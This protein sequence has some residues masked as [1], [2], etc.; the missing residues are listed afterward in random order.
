[1]E[2]NA[3]QLDFPDEWFD[4][5]SVFTVFSS[6]L[7]VR[8]AKSVAQN[9]ARVLSSRGVVVWYD[10]RY[11]N[12]WNPAIRPMTISSIRGLFPSFELQLESSTLLPPVAR[13]LGR[14]TDL[15]YP[16]LA[17][18]PI[19]RSHYIGLLRPTRDSGE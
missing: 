19:L 4:L 7:E 17:S 16:L 14:L 8:M 12:P 11:P 13:Q 2:G 15:A 5:V 1:L 3:E 6:I 18:I 9:I 10:V